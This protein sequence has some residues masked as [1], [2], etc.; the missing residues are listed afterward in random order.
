GREDAMAGGVRRAVVVLLGAV[1]FV[2]LIA[3]ANLANLLLVRAAA[4]RREIAIRAALGASRGRILRQLLT[5]SVLLAAL[6]G[7]AGLLLAFS[8][9]AALNSLGPEALPRMR[10]VRL[11]GPV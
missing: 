2:L 11:H 5:E 9:T 7:A 10:A 6:G 1:G 4:R 8:A 3:C